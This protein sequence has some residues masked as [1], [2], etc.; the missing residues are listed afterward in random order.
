M[1]KTTRNWTKSLTIENL[2]RKIQKNSP[3]MSYWTWN[4]WMTKTLKMN[5]WIETKTK[6]WIRNSN[7]YSLRSW[8]NSVKTSLKKIEKNWNWMIPN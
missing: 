1:K 6:N 2:M 7:C 3:T 4:Y 8:T 5:C